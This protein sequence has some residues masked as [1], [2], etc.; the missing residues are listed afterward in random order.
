[1]S[2]YVSKNSKILIEFF[3]N[4]TSISYNYRIPDWSK[5]VE[6]SV[7]LNLIESLPISDLNVV[8]INVSDDSVDDFLR[9]KLYLS[10]K[11]LEIW[12]SSDISTKEAINL[13]KN[14]L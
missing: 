9:L 7:I 14:S 6:D 12:S 8:H 10:M 13:I 5:P 2:K 11:K 4:V 3:S 1:M